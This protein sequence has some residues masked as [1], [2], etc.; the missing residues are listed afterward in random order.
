MG[1]AS[2]NI[3]TQPKD[4]NSQ[5][6]YWLFLAFRKIRTVRQEKIKTA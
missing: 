5:S 1:I 6:A 2:K 3:S 4:H